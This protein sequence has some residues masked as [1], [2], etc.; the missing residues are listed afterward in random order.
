LKTGLYLKVSQPPECGQMKDG[1][2]LFKT[3]YPVTLDIG[4]VREMFE[5]NSLFVTGV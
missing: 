2:G 5:M 1:R 4:S 3:G